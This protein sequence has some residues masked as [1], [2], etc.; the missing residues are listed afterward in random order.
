MTKLFAV[1]FAALLLT[2][3]TL[4]PKTDDAMTATDTT[5]PAMEDTTTT[6]VAADPA[7]DPAYQQAMMEA[8]AAA[9]AAAMA[10]TTTDSG[11]V[12]AT[13]TADAAVAQ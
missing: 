5:A 8:Q 1:L 10:A 7:Q 13:V 11:A 2:G 9:E 6:E 3:C 4:S 12:E